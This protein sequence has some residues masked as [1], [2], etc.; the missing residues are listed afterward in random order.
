L[1]CSV[2]NGT[3]RLHG[4]C[5]P[6][7]VVWSAA[8]GGAE[9]L[10]T[11]LI[12]GEEP[13]LVRAS[14]P[15]CLL[16][17]TLLYIGSVV[18]SATDSVFKLLRLVGSGG[19]WGVAEARGLSDGCWRRWQRPARIWIRAALALG[20]LV[21][22]MLLWPILA[23]AWLRSASRCSA[24]MVFPAL[25]RHLSTRTSRGAR[26]CPR[27]IGWVGHILWLAKAKPPAG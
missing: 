22:R 26:L 27:V 17:N 4:W 8:C 21:G 15:L 7:L 9:C 1:P 20:S 2:S 5:A 25:R 16:S 6:S 24:S 18:W 14:D 3:I 19:R 10:S 12:S 23:Q 11:R 13:W